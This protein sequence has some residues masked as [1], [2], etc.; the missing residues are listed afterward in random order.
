[1]NASCS[2]FEVVPC[3]AAS[4]SASGEEV[5]PSGV[6]AVGECEEQYL[7]F[8][9]GVFGHPVFTF[10]GRPLNS[11][12]PASRARQISLWFFMFPSIT[13]T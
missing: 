13:R 2:S 4:V 6:K 12:N 1:M 5:S 7:Q 9:F 8:G 10:P 11:A 3:T